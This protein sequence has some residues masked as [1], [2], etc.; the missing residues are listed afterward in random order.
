MLLGQLPS[1]IAAGSAGMYS[2]A[3][4]APALMQAFLDRFGAYRLQPYSVPKIPAQLMTSTFRPRGLRESGL[5]T[6][7]VPRQQKSRSG[8]SGGNG[9]TG[10]GPRS[11]DRNGGKQ[12]GGGGF[13]G[14]V[15][16]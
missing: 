13:G 9:R 4:Y 15:S 1:Q 7:A 3:G 8:R 6:P 14:N 12:G 10:G 16:T 11:A 5:L 2:R